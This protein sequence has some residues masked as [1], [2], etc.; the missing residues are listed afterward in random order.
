MLNLGKSATGLLQL[1]IKYL[2]FILNTT[3]TMKK[4]RFG[5]ARTLYPDELDTLVASFPYSTPKILAA[6]LR[7]S[8]G[9]CS[10]IAQSQWKHLS[11]NYLLLPAANTKTNRSRS[12]P[13]NNK[14]RLEL[15]LWEQHVKPKSSEEFSFSGRFPNSYYKRQSFDKALRKY[16]PFE[17]ISTHTFRRSVLTEMKRKGRG[18]GAQPPRKK[19]PHR[20]TYVGHTLWHQCVKMHF[21]M[22]WL[23]P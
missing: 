3:K 19:S 10:E 11:S 20:L 7:F 22:Y 6:T 16:S 4:D 2:F 12:I 17:D 21:L 15:E 9:R 13:I 14:L 5:K 1:L 8:G 18:D 23:I